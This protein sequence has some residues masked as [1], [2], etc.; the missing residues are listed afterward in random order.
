MIIIKIKRS[1]SLILVLLVVIISFGLM[2]TNSKYTSTVNGSVSTSVA[3]YVFKM[4]GSDSHDSK[5]TIKNLTLADT[6]D[7]ST[8]ASGKIAPGTS[9]SFNI[10]VDT[11]DS[12]VGIGYQIT[13]DSNSNNKLPTNLLLTLDGKPWTFDKGIKGTI[14]ANQNSNVITHTINWNWAYQTTNGDSID[15]SDGQNSFDY[16]YNVTATGTQIK[17][18]KE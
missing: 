18:I 4:T 14:Y 5:H 10:I 12:E 1:I 17:P 9:G 6:C 3:K 11:T 2:Y 16:S 7:I 13:F 15:T 8:L